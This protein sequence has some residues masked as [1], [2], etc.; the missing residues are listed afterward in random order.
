MTT[1][2]EDLRDRY[3]RFKFRHFTHNQERYEEL[4]VK[5]VDG[6]A[7]PAE[8]QELMAW[9]HDKPELRAEL[10]EHLG[11]KAITDDWVERVRFDEVQDAYDARKSPQLVNLLGVALVLLGSAVVLLPALQE[12]ATD[13]DVPLGIVLGLVVSAAGPLSARSG[14]GHIT[15]VTITGS[16]NP[17]S[18]DYLMGAIDQAEAEG[19]AAVLIELDTPGGL[20]ASTIDILHGPSP[21]LSYV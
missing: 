1:F 7:T 20:V 5:V 10:Q 13:P 15:L 12:L 8:R 21:S 14:G 9:V 4:V 3:L 16:I 6:M 17:A 18:A 19:A 11:L 2:P